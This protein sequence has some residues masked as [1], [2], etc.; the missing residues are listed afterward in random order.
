MLSE[1]DDGERAAARPRID[2]PHRFHRAEQK[3]LPAAPPL[4]LDRQAPFEEEP[5]LECPELGELGVHQ[6]FIEAVELLLSHRT[7]QV[8][9][10][11]LVVAAGQERAFGV[12]G[13]GAY[14][15]R[16]GIIEIEILAARELLYR[17]AE[18]LRGKWACRDDRWALGDLAHLLAD[19][20]YGA[21]RL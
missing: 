6:R 5:L 16:D 1:L 14:D 20:L 17:L 3:R 4:F 21:R 8:V 15:G 19:D 2:E 13:T 12:Y 10:S 7:V 11:S 18:C 9:G